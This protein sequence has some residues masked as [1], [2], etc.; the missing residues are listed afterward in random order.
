MGRDTNEA[1]EI[2]KELNPDALFPDGFEDAII[3]YVE[4][5]GDPILILMDSWKCIEILN[6][7]M[8]LEEALEYFQFNVLGSW[9]GENTPMFATLITGE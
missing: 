7:D 6:K 4:R 3:G 5:C 8:S 1:L 2:I 9:L